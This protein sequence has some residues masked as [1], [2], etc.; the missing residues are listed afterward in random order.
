[1]R[2]RVAAARLRRIG[3]V[4]LVPGEELLQ[5]AAELLGAFRGARVLR[6]EVEG[7]RRQRIE[8]AEIAHLPTVDG[9]HAEDADDDL[10]GHAVLLL[11]P[12]QGAAVLLPEAH[13]GGDARPV[14]EAAAVD[15]PVLGLSW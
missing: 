1:S 4:L 11:G 10:R 6:R 15:G 2:T 3:V 13:A 14:D 7:E 12:L 8:H 5:V 9:L